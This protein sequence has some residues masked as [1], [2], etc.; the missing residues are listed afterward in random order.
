MKR[1]GMAFFVIVFIVSCGKA[2]R[3]EVPS[4]KPALREKETREERFESYLQRRLKEGN[5]G[6]AERQYVLF[7]LSLLSPSSLSNGVRNPTLAQ[8]FSNEF[9]ELWNPQAYRSAY[10]LYLSLTNTFV[11]ERGFLLGRAG[12]VAFKGKQ[13]SLAINTLRE[14]F[15]SSVSEEMLYYYGLWH[16]YVQTNKQKAREIFSRISPEHV[17]V[18]YAEWGSFLKDEQKLAREEKTPVDVLRTSSDPTLRL[19]AFASWLEQQ[20]VSGEPIWSYRFVLPPYIP[21][22]RSVGYYLSPMAS[23]MPRMTREW[24]LPFSVRP[25]KPGPNRYALFLEEPLVGESFLLLYAQPLVS[26]WSSGYRGIE[27]IFPSLSYTNV[28]FVYVTPQRDTN[29]RMTNLLLESVN[30]PVKY[31]LFCSRIYREGIWQYA[32]VGFTPPSTIDVVVMNPVTRAMRK[33]SFSL[34]DFQ[35]IYYADILGEEKMS[36]WAVGKTVTRLPDTVVSP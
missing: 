29:D 25:G 4:G 6:E 34:L 30:V 15:E 33:V 27:P 7:R 21:T 35:Q 19:A 20:S 36:W 18:S 8:A 23:Q 31:F 17:G 2:S 11:Q 10:T 13:Y 28:F 1:Y 22:N 32:V 3:A 12:I 9:L 26:P 5:L 14:A 24:P 16:W